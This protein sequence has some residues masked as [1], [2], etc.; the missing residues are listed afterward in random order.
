MIKIKTLKENEFFIVERSL[1]YGYIN[2]HYYNENKFEGKYRKLN[3]N[4]IKC[5]IHTLNIL[6]YGCDSD[7]IVPFHPNVYEAEIQCNKQ[8]ISEL[9][10]TLL[11]L[12]N[13]IEGD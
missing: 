6:Y 2:I 9:M 12:K 13:E 11:R 3:T 4:Q 5:I 1:D 10:R 8:Q 7:I